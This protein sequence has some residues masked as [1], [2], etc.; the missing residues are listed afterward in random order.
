MIKEMLETLQRS[1]KS[2]IGNGHHILIACL[3]TKYRR[4]GTVLDECNGED[5]KGNDEVAK[6]WTDVVS[7]VV[8]EVIRGIGYE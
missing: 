2:S 4:K 3:R 7:I 6:H 5:D 8:F 1:T